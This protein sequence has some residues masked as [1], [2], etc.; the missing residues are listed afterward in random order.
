MSDKK[1]ARKSQ[2]KAPGTRYGTPLNWRAGS[3][4]SGKATD[5]YGRSVR[6]GR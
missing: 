1:N 3:P 6:D 4:R 2:R 5:R